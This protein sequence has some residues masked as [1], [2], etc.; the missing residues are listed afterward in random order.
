[1]NDDKALWLAIRRA[2]LAIVAA[3]ERRFDL[4]HTD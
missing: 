3:I 2:L 1:V 4:K